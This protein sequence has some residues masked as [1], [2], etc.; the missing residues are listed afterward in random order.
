M[1]SRQHL[2][3]LLVALAVGAAVV[4][5]AVGSAGARIPDCDADPPP[6]DPICGTTTTTSTPAPPGP[7]ARQVVY[8]E[9]DPTVRPA[10]EA[11]L[12]EVLERVRPA[13]RTALAGRTVRLHVI[14][15]DRMVTE[16]APWAVHRGEQTV[17]E[18]PD[19]DYDEVRPWDEVRGIAWCDP[20]EAAVGEERVTRLASSRYQ[21]PVDASL[22]RTLFHEAGHIVHCSFSEQQEDRLDALY[23]AARAR[24]RDTVVGANPDYSVA[25]RGEYFAEA[26][27]AWF[28]AGGHASYSRAWLQANDPGLLD[29]LGTIYHTP[30]TVPRCLGIRATKVLGTPGT[31]TG[32]PGRDIVA[33][34]SG[35]DVI[36]TAGGDDL[37]CGAGGNDEI[38]GGDGNDEIDG[39][40]GADVLHGDAGSDRLLGRSGNDRL[41]G[42]A[43]SDYLAGGAGE[44]RYFGGDGDDFLSDDLYADGPADDYMDGG[45]GDDTMAGG[46]GNDTFLDYRGIDE[47]FGGD[48][49]DEMYAVDV[50]DPRLPTWTAPADRL[51]G[52]TG[53]NTC[54]GDP[55]DIVY[56]CFGPGEG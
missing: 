5:P 16:Y 29:L 13:N 25:D 2:T 9:S 34:S 48:G 50:T 26:T 33:G 49:N 40:T 39:G 56:S 46:A 44:D 51:D 14:P 8:H 18:N 35:R 6:T 31:F 21:R 15:S 41:Y 11:Y 19:D 27:A 10:A 24:P 30:L 43:G 37:V 42:E 22:G 23:T 52:M 36:T 45:P 3:R 47:M 54:T 12:N 53:Q 7:I 4:A 20:L 32:G 1:T 55:I 17:D 38:H 28:E